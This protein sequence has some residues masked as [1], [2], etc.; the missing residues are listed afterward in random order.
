MASFSESRNEGLLQRAAAAHD[1]SEV[2]AYRE[3]DAYTNMYIALWELDDEKIVRALRTNHHIRS[4]VFWRGASPPIPQEIQAEFQTEFQKR[5]YLFNI[6]TS[7]DVIGKV[8]M[9]CTLVASDEEYIDL[10]AL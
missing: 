10:S 6:A 7:T 5:G 2:A 9:T 3:T 4:F 1:L 8:K